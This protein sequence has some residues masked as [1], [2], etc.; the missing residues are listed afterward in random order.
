MQANAINPQ[1]TLANTNAC[2]HTPTPTHTRPHMPSHSHTRP[3]MPT[4]AQALFKKIL[5]HFMAFKAYL[6]IFRGFR[7][8]FLDNFV[9]N[10]TSFQTTLFTIFTAFQTTLFTFFTAF[11]TTLFTIF[12][13]FQTT[14]YGF[15]DN[16]YGFFCFAFYAVQILLRSTKV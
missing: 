15:V 12:T 5:R 7:S 1:Q 3:H 10:F 4:H 16:F 13:A 2:P 9:Y 8:G 14:F 6:T 11:L